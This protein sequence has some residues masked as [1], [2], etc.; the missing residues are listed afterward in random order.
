V[1]RHRQLP[2]LF[3]SMWS[4]CTKEDDMADVASTVCGS[5][6]M[7]RRRA[8][9]LGLA[10]GLALGTSG[11]TRRVMA[12]FPLTEPDVCPVDIG[13]HNMMVF[14]E[15]SVFL[16]HLPM[17]VGL[18][19]DGAHFVTEHRFQLIL[20][21]SFEGQRTRRDVT[22]LYK[23]DR[24]RNPEIRMY[25][26]GPKQVFALA[27]IFLPPTSGEPRRS[28]PA[29]V[30]RGHLERPGGEIIRGLSG[31]TIRIMR[32]VYVHEF[33]PRDRSPDNLEYILFGTPGELF[34]VHRIVAPGNF[35]QILPVR[36]PDQQFS[37]ADL[38]QGLR[39][40]VPGRPNVSSSRLREGQNAAAQLLRTDAQARD[41][42]L[43]TLREIYFEESEL[44][45]PLVGDTQEERDAGF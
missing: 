44:A 37:D 3:G 9:G 43:Q 17:F 41:I 40:V 29:D 16:S 5:S 6:G 24:Q 27:E 28:F 36:V 13:V 45:V 38:S 7:S 2:P 25:S 42:K 8:L 10:F 39:V 33:R 22:E 20:E 30:F 34:L 31:V 18:C 12:Q 26:L 19:D 4:V 11:G 1:T 15:R 32:V 14:G 21:A 35:D 23:Q